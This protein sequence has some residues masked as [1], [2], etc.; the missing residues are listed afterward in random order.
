MMRIN[1][2]SRRYFSAEIEPGI[3]P[4]SGQWRWTLYL[5]DEIVTSDYAP[6]RN[7]A[8][9]AAGLMADQ[10]ARPRLVSA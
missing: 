5:R 7:A 9:A 10:T 2:E 4:R 3:G 8:M 1:W 6:D